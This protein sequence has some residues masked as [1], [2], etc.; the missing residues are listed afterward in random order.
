MKEVEVELKKQEGESKEIEQWKELYQEVK[1]ENKRLSSKVDE[2]YR[3]QHQL[4]RQLYDLQ[5]NLV[6]YSCMRVCDKRMRFSLDKKDAP[7]VPT[8]QTTQNS[9]SR[10]VGQAV[11]K[12][13]GM[14]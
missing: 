6:S 11:K 8:A 9:P 12:E 7:T 13:V 1:S 5:S 14:Y 10:E 4:T 3:Q 2:L